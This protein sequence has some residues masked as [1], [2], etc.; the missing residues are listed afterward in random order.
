[1]AVAG[2]C[3]VISLA[4]QGGQLAIL[5]AISGIILAKVFWLF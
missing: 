5:Q 1:M 4:E 3:C 2:M